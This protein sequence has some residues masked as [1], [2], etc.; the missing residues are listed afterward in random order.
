MEIISCITKNFQLIQHNSKFKFGTD[1]VLLADFSNIKKK[2][3]V[4]DFCC[5]TGAIGYMCYIKYRQKHT[6]LVDIDSEMVELCKK[7]A[8][9]NAISNNFSFICSDISNLNEINNHS[10]DYITVN[11]PYFKQ[12]SGKTNINKNLINARHTYNFS[13]DTLFSKAYNILK[14]GGKISIVQRAEN[15]ADI[16]CCMK[17]NGIEPKVL[18]MVHSYADCNAVLFLL[19]GMKKA[20]VGLKILPPLVL[21]KE[22]G[23][24]SDEFKNIQ[25]NE[26]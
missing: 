1:A 7:T 6:Y 11:P 24:F 9:L 16:I 23:V 17:N 26:M 8:E 13:N 12:N 10:I 5:G 20:G 2:D 18:R 4:A 3:V 21:Y 19:E 15:L 22:K 14:D 25:M